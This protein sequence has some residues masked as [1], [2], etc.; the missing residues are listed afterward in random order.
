MEKIENFA[1]ISP[2]EQRAFAEALVKTINTEKTFIDDELVIS[3]V[4]ADEM[5]G[6]LIIELDA[7]DVYVDRR[8]TWTAS[9]DGYE[10]SAYEKP[11]DPEYEDSI[12]S[13]AEK[14][15]KTLSVEMDG[16]TLTLA[17]ADTDAD[18][19]E[20][21]KVDNV[22]HEDAGIG[23]YEYWGDIGYD[24]RPYLEVE[25]TLVT[26]CKVYLSLL[27]ESTANVPEEAPEE[28]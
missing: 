18:E 8:A 15:F 2:E 28:A 23:Q 25:G 16:Y 7:D 20:E 19:I 14:A 3:G 22:S 17:V 5:T 1:A 26:S 9:D 27:V 12:F 11:E 21:V 6:D 24:S 13:D 4:E 10:D